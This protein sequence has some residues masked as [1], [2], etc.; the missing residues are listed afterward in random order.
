MKTTSAIPALLLGLLVSSVTAQTNDPGDP[1]NLKRYEG[2]IVIHHSD[3]KYTPYRIPL[4][5]WTPTPGAEPEDCYTKK[6]DVEG[7]LKRL[8]YLIPDDKRTAIEVQRNYLDELPRSGWEILFEGKG[9]RGL[10]PNFG[11]KTRLREPVPNSQL[12]EY[13][14]REET[15]FVAARRTDSDGDT[16]ATFI[17]TR[18]TMGL[19]GPFDGMVKTNHILVRAD[20]IKPR[21]LE[22]RMVFVDAKQMQG[23]IATKGRIALYGILFDFNKA[24]I[25]PESKPTLDEIAKLLKD[26]P[27]LKLLVVGHTDNVGTLEFNRDLSARRAAS[28]VKELTGT[29]GI[30]SGR[31]HAEGVAFLCPVDQNDTD[32]GRAKNRRVELV[33]W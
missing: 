7:S 18:Y 5:K 29:Y 27:A 26:N 1:P 11:Y 22:Q 20:V 12:L 15:A 16:Y 25:K 2:S 14:D 33:K 24:D 30:S 3:E 23:D 28:V 8:V 17:I 13:P 19:K 21:A 9:E 4:S 32:E 31:L 6:M 10:H